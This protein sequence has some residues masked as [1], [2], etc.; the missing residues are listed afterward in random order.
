ML[1]RIAAWKSERILTVSEYSKGKLNE[2]LG[3]SMNR[4]SVVYNAWQHFEKVQS[5]DAVLSR[6]GLAWGGVFLLSQ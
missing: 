1:C 6:L 4:I 5:E 2:L 3:I